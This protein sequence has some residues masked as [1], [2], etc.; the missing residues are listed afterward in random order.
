[1]AS[2]GSKK[3]PSSIRRDAGIWEQLLE[4]KAVTLETGTLHEAQVFQLK[5]W[6]PLA[7]PQAHDIEI[8]V[9]LPHMTSHPENKL[10]EFYRVEVRAKAETAPPRDLKNRLEGLCRSI[11]TLLGD[12]F[13]I[14][15]K[16][17]GKTIFLKKGAR[18]KSASFKNTYDRLK[19]N[20]K[21]TK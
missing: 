11:R 12:H 3:I 5:L 20:V 19:K 6:G 8:A 4:L 7:L 9:G 2:K 21:T 16:I 15:V 14:I 18:K 1:M 13:D 10:V 17:N